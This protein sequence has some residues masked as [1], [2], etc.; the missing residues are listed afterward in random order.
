MSSWLLLLLPTLVAAD[1]PTDECAF[2]KLTYDFALLQRPDLAPL[3]DVFDALELAHK[4]GETRPDPMTRSW[5]CFPTP[6]A[7]AFYVSTTGSDSSSGTKAKP[8][9]T[10]G[11]AV[12]AA[13]GATAN[14]TILLR[15]G[16]HHLSGTIALTAADSGLT[17]QN[18]ECEEAWLSGGVPVSTN[19]T[20][21]QPASAAAAAAAPSCEDQC[22][23]EGHCCEGAVSSYQHPSCAMGCLMATSGGAKDLDECEAGCQSADGQ[24]EYKFKG[25]L[26]LQMCESCPKGCDASD[27]VGEC[28]EGC[29]LAFGVGGPN[30]WVTTLASDAGV[31]GIDGLFTLEPHARFT[32]ARWPNPAS[33]TIER[34]PFANVQPTRWLPPAKVP[35]AAQVYVNATA[36]DNFTSSIL[37]H[38]N[39][40]ASGNCAS[41]YDKQ[42][43]CGAWSDVRDGVWTSSSYWCSDKAS[44]GWANMDVGNGYYNGPILPVG[45][46][47]D[48]SDDKGPKSQARFDKYADAKGAIV[49]AWRA[50]GWFNNMYEVESHDK[51]M[52]TLRWSKGGFQGGRGWQ[53]NGTDGSIDPTPPFFIENVFEE[54]DMPGEWFYNRSTRL[55]FFMPN[56]TTPGEGPPADTQFVVPKLQRL[57]TVIGTL[58]EPVRD[59]RVRGLG[60]RDARATYMEPWGVPSGGDWALHRGAAVFL[61]RTSDVIVE[62]NTFRRVD[63]NALQL[64]GFNRRAK[65]LENEFAWIGDTAMSAWGYTDEEDGTGGDQPRGTLVEGNV[66]HEVGMFQLQSACWFQAKT[67]TTR[68]ASNLFFNG[69]RSGINFNDGFG[70]GNEVVKNVIFNEC[71]Q[72]GDHGPINSWD[73]QLFW[74]DLKDGP[75]KPGWNPAYSSVWQNVIIANYGGSQGFDNDDGSSWWDIHHNVIL[76]EGL[77]QDYGGHDSMYHD[78][79]NLV[80][81]YD[82]QNCINTWPF[83]RGAGPCGNWSAGKEECSHAH[84]F[85]RNR[86]ILLYNTTDYSPGAGGC[87]PDLD[88]MP[89]LRDNSYFTMSGEA[90]MKGCGSLA[91]LQNGGAE[92]GSTQATLPAQSQWLGWAKDILEM[93]KPAAKEIPALAVAAAGTTP[94]SRPVAPSAA[95]A[96]RRRVPATTRTGDCD[97]GTCCGMAHY[98]VRGTHH[99]AE[100]DVPALPELIDEAATYYIYYNIDWQRAGPE[101]SDARMNQFVPQLMLGNALSGSSGAPYYLPEWHMSTSWI[102]G[103][104]YFFELFNQTTNST[105]GKAAVGTAYPAVEGEVLYT[106]FELDDTYEWTITMGV[107]G[108]D[109]RTSVV[110]VPKP[111]MGLLPEEQT[112]SWAEDVYAS[113]WSNSCWELYG[114]DQTGKRYPG[115]SRYDMR[116]KVDEATQG[117]FDWDTDWHFSTPDCPGHPQ[118]SVGE[119]HTAAEQHVLWNL[120]Y[121]A[122]IA[123]LPA[124]RAGAG[125]SVNAAAVPLPYAMFASAAM[126]WVVPQPPIQKATATATTSDPTPMLS[127]K[128]STDF[129]MYALLDADG[130]TLMHGSGASL[131]CDGKLWTSEDGLQLASTQTLQGDDGPGRG[132]WTGVALTW[133]TGSGVTLVTTAKNYEPDDASPGTGD[134][135]FEWNL[136]DGANRTS[137]ASRSRDA[138]VVTWPRFELNDEG[139]P[140][141]ATASS[142]SALGGVLS[143]EGSFM[144]ANQR[145]STGARG[146]PTVFFD[147]ADPALGIALVGAPLGHWKASSA[148]ENRKPGRADEKAWAPGLSATVTSLPEGFTHGLWLKAGHGVTATIGA[149]GEAVRAWRGTTRA[150]DV[151][152]EK[153]GYQTDNGA[154]YVFCSTGNCSKTMLDVQSSLLEQGIPLG[155]LS[156]QGAGASSSDGGAPWCVSTW[157]I[158]GGENSKQFPLS[159][160]EL[161]A[162]LG[163]PLQLYAPY[164]CNNSQYFQPGAKPLGGWSAYTSDTTLPGCGS[165]FFKVP[166]V[167]DAPAFYEQ[168]F[169]RGAAAGMASFEPDFMNQNYNCMPE[170]VED[171]T[172]APAWQKAMNDAAQ[173]TGSP[174]QWC[175]ATPTDALA[176]LDLPYI[177]NMR[178]ST[179]F[180]YGSSWDI[181]LSSLL[182]WAVGQ[183]PSKDTLWTS[184]NGGFEVPGCDWTADHERPAAPLHVLLALLSTGP[185]GISD[186]LHQTNATLALRMIRADGVLLKPARPITSVDATLAADGAPPGQLMQTHSPSDPASVARVHL[187]LSFLMDASWAVTASQLYPAPALDDDSP[188]LFAVR[189]FDDS[190]HVGCIDGADA[191]AGCIDALVS[192]GKPSDILFTAP[193]SDKTNV[194]GGTNYRP[195]LTA[196]WPVCAP[197]GWVLLGELDKYVPL[198]TSRFVKTACATDGLSA[199]VCGAPAEAPITV[200]VLKPSADGKP[201]SVVVSKQ[202]SFPPAGGCVDLSWMHCGSDFDCSYNGECSAD[203]QACVCDAGW[204]GVA[205]EQLDLLP[206]V[207]GSGLDELHVDPSVA[208]PT[209]TWG[210]SVL[211]ADDGTYHMWASEMT[212][213]CGIHRWLSNSVVV[214]ATAPGP[215]GPFTKKQQV[216]GLFS[217]EPVAQRAPTGE[218]VLFFTSFPGAASDAP[219]CN[220]SDGNSASG[221]AGCEGEPGRGANKTL[222]SYMSYSASPDGPWSTPVLLSSKALDPDG[223]VDTNI[224]PVILPDGSLIAWTRWDAWSASDWRDATTYKDEGQAIAWGNVSF[225]EGED[226]F[227]YL[228]RKGRFHMISHNGARG[229][230]GT[231]AEPSGDC[232]RHFFSTSGKAGTW[233]AVAE[234]ASALGGCAYPRTNVSF[235]DGT[236]RSFYRRERPHL[237]FGADGFTPIALTTAAIDSPIGPG[238]PGFVGPQR[239]ASFTLLQ[240]INSHRAGDGDGHAR[241][242]L[243]APLHMLATAALGFHDCIQPKRD[244]RPPHVRM[245][246]PLGVHPL[247]DRARSESPADC[248]GGLC[249]GMHGGPHEGGPASY[250]VGDAASGFTSVYSTMT[251][252]KPPKKTD[253][254]TYYI[255]TDIFFGDMSQGRMNQFVPQLILGAALDG[256]SGPPDFKPHW[257]E[258]QTWS[259]GAH[260]FFETLNAT[261]ANVDS[262][263]AYGPLFPA[264]VGE[265][266]FTSF[267]AT[268]SDAGPVWTLQMGALNDPSRLSEVKIPQP[269]M[270]LGTKWATPS[271]RWDEKNFSNMCINACWELYGADD[272]DHLPSSGSKYAVHVTRAPSA[273]FPWVE[274]WDEDEGANQSCAESAIAETHNQTVQTI[275]WN[276]SVPAPLAPTTSLP[277]P[278]AP[279]T[280]RTPTLSTNALFSDHMVIQDQRLSPDTP[281]TTLYGHAPP[282]AVVTLSGLPGGKQMTEADGDGAWALEIYRDRG[283]DPEAAAG[284]YDLTLA[285]GDEQ[286]FARDVYFGDVFL[287][288]G[289]SNME[290]TVDYIINATAELASADQPLLRL[291]Q[292]PSAEP[293]PKG[294]WHTPSRE[295]DGSCLRCLDG[296]PCQK[297]PGKG[298]SNPIREWAVANASVVAKFSAI[299]YLSVRDA[300]RLLHVDGRP[301]GL[302]E[303]DWG[304][305]PVQAW[306]PPAALTGCGLPTD[307]CKTEPGGNCTAYPSV[308]F[309]HMVSPLVGYGLRAVLWMQGEANSNEGFPLDRPEY[310]C[311]FGAMIDAWRAAWLSP[312]L[313]FLFVQISAWC[314][315][316]AESPTAP[317]LRESSRPQVSRLPAIRPSAAQVWQLGLR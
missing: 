89:L 228:D 124:N 145:L 28:L 44:G 173:K 54:L 47:Y 57:L 70:G 99:Y 14:G 53:L 220:C 113:A 149:W 4:C 205:C 235:A 272:L 179:D 212:R 170:F 1:P 240:P 190:G 116:V 142:P 26:E 168:L 13:R 81:Q 219:T 243:P 117:S 114:M 209:S 265:T 77:K 255:W 211:R 100:F 162:A 11:H 271:T 290:R 248:N 148:G 17:I 294:P 249:L 146:G 301:V 246:H 238:M 166:T 251:V 250:P 245:A 297:L 126:G 291:F 188:T 27:G 147:K 61:E 23:A 94:P 129:K 293:G 87:P 39:A 307:D 276:I 315:R 174:V 138:V 75:S 175:Y 163:I 236:R 253:G 24:C 121:P 112:K 155:Y 257:G 308:L 79:L 164:F 171:T 98:P 67:A 136:P 46:V 105:Q 269:Y 92:R 260:Y 10:V 3:L 71:R 285:A 51:A 95:A 127:I 37:E 256:S 267:V 289:Q 282:G 264:T 230:G 226:P 203:G 229:R 56:A 279:R 288:S 128:L 196:A 199:T 177:T 35:M 154:Y 270:G 132:S 153:I 197:S 231:A 161:H 63:G 233:N 32:R 273:T 108:D 194:T 304:G 140:A 110:H 93:A 96:T 207:N 18:F 180:C 135:A 151:T 210:G 303:S 224:S 119:A 86:C 141:G 122:A 106:S 69:P 139:A 156:F 309:N 64:S 137:Q 82:G 88:S 72:S 16:V 45:M 241:G 76:G 52:H 284:P 262:H 58:A 2:R 306:S 21:W 103:A 169:A 218:Y 150:A 34:R 74:T 242:G 40:Y 283:M 237:I 36:R 221:E 182:P 33:G 258:H 48:A 295:L 244:R 143:W 286:L 90:T 296:A 263:A 202:V 158:D 160:G 206:A 259:F 109:S 213:S 274:Q 115:S 200:T 176:T 152:L 167:A 165:Y 216:F 192:L 144:G 49:V 234:P 31:D 181:G 302:I 314:A 172:T 316:L 232:G 133:R 134:V 287:C 120:T 261:S 80:Q 30:I 310:A 305:T 50:Q 317:R 62:Q 68:I 280:P 157:G 9:A 7:G 78:N 97:G 217:H 201:A 118:Q 59:V 312:A 184:D 275:S 38:Y 130:H 311:A 191:A 55:L 178:V 239:D 101:G 131:F 123:T 185:V 22:K 104:Q 198:A 300:M 73:R 83:K 91:D 247:D 20:K 189:A 223:R 5:P 254:I 125:T 281:P 215:L 299:C 187:F 43:P 298:C 186:A 204:T 19:W 65:L 225:W 214:H 222:Y 266:L 42:C 29:R 15:A 12:S 227:V 66:C 25:S 60:F 41:A 111:F 292:V 208:T 159:V 85:E 6:P 313:P 268:P 193:A 195:M 278:L 102:F 84:R 107:K 252:P 277:P 8:F 183:A